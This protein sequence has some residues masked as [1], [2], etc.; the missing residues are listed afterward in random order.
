MFG[1][2]KPEPQTM[3]TKPTKNSDGT[4]ARPP[5]VSRKGGLGCAKVRATSRGWASSH[6]H[7][8][9]TDCHQR[10]A[11]DHAESFPEV[12]I[13][14]VTAEQRRQVDEARVEA[15][16]GRGGALHLPRRGGGAADY[17]DHQARAEAVVELIGEQLGAEVE[18][19]DGAHAVEGEALPHLDGEEDG[20][21]DGV[22]EA[23]G[24]PR[25]R[26]H[27]GQRQRQASVCS[28]GK[29]SAADLKSKK[30]AS[31]S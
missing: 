25:L 20:E 15:V 3:N 18:D 1:L 9:V 29:A 13:G 8:E 22:P 14:E 27:A 4:C 6:H 23:L 5:N 30:K 19:E 31:F 21:A 16:D 17:R 26:G 2:K 28:L 7:H 24:A 10:Q 12:S 11:E